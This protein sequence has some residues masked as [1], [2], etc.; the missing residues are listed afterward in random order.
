MLKLPWAFGLVCLALFASHGGEAAP[1]PD[2]QNP[3][4]SHLK[5]SPK[6]KIDELVLRRLDQL[7][8]SP[9]PLCSDAV[10]LRRACLDLVGLLPTP[11]ETKAFLEDRHPEK[12]RRWVDSLLQR[13]AFS[14]YWAMKWCDLL[15]VKAEFPINLWPNAAQ[16]YHRWI[17]TSLQQKVPYDRFV[18]ELLTSS[19]SNFRSPPVNFYRAL[20]S[21]EPNGIASAVALTFMGVRIEKWTPAQ[22][23]NL[24]RFFSK[25]GYKSTGEW[26]E[27]IVF[28]D[29]LKG[30]MGPSE[31]PMKATLPDDS[32]VEIGRD[33]DP[34]ITFADWLVRPENP[35]F[36]RNIANRAWAWLLGRGIIHEPDDISSSNPPQNAELLSYLEKELVAANYDLTHL[37]RLIATSETYQ[38]SSLSRGDPEASG[39]NFASYS[40]RRLGAETLIDAIC[41]VTGS[42]EKYSS[43]IPEPFSFLPEDQKATGLP[44]GSISS[45]FLELFGRPPRDTG[46]ESERNNRLTAA[47]SLHLLNS[48]HIQ[49]KIERSRTLTSLAANRTTPKQLVSEIYLTVLS[50]PPTPVEMERIAAYRQTSQRAQ[51]EVV[52]DLAW[53]LIN[54]TE[55]LYRH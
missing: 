40:V 1:Q 24:A 32:V 9:A 29:S 39:R 31:P 8:I 34:R 21:K 38:L 36:T 11:Q 18:R 25:V 45:P 41:Q 23:T 53:A 3:F 22:Q 50:R 35:W 4:E 14:D 47:Q 28:F 54:S 51:R 42:T 37:L 17:R 49:R 26:K 10:F 19:G 27:E 5:L 16:A 30:G 15:R 52:I 44:D 55:F 6:T 46:L 13:E 33:Q 7:G 12:R 2:A 48:S 20:Q 43:P